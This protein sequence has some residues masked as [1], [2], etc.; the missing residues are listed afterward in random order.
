MG[1]FEGDFLFHDIVLHLETSR[2]IQ[3]IS[4]ETPPPLL[5]LLSPSKV[6]L[7]VICYFEFLALAIRLSSCQSLSLF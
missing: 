6:I 7:G 4:P 2:L 1:K 5:S 3:L